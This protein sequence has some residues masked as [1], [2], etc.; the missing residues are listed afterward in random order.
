M[1][2]GEIMGVQRFGFRTFRAENGELRLNGKSVYL[3]GVLPNWFVSEN[4][5]YAFAANPDNVARRYY[6]QF[7][8]MNVNEFRPNTMTLYRR[9]YELMDELGFLVRDELSYPSVLL[10]NSTRAEHIDTK[11]YD[12]ACG[13]D[14][15]LHPE[16]ARKTAERLFRYY[17]HPCIASYSFGNELR[18]YSPRITTMLNHLYDL[19]EKLDLQHRPRMSSSGRYWFTGSN[20]REL[21]EKKEKY[22]FISVHDYTGGPSSLPLTAAEDAGRHFDQEVEAVH[23]KGK[24]PVVN[25]ECVYFVDFYYQQKK[26]LDRIWKSKDAPEPEWDAY[27]DLLNRWYARTPNAKLVAYFFRQ[28]GTRNLKYDFST[29][30]SYHVERILE[31]NRKLWPGRDGF[32]ILMTNHRFD[33]FPLPKN[34]Y[35]FSQVRFPWS[36]ESEAMRRACAPVGAFM[37]LVKGNLFT[38]QEYRNR[39]TVIN[40]SA[41]EIP[42]LAVRLDLAGAD[43]TKTVWKQKVGLLKTGEKTT[44]PFRLKL[45]EKAGNFELRWQIETLIPVDRRSTRRRCVWNPRNGFSHGW[46]QGIGKFF[47]LTKRKN[48]AG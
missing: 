47:C 39:I 42:D 7:K 6:Q 35:P 38:G 21:Y 3:R 11:Q 16:F 2:P 27:L 17:S 26:I 46:R 41:W 45:P 22:D 48:S 30:R 1:S 25:G 43:G 20:I 14:G 31:A 19:Y 8:N 29:W 32:D 12:N 23:G 5:I 13:P 10:K 37:D 4:A 15:R 44:L 33:F 34:F 40:N 28:M 18:D 24:I 9:Q 36:P